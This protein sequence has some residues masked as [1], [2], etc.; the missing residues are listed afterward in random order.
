MS[1]QDASFLH[2]ENRVNPMSIASMAI[3]E[4]PAPEYDEMLKLF[5]S[6]LH[7]VPRYRQTVRFVPL[8]LARPLWVDDPHF[9]L[10][11][12][13]RHTAIPHPGS[14]EQVR[15]LMARVMSQRLDR[16][17]PLWE[18]WIADGLDGGKRWAVLSKVHHCM[19]DGVS[20]T[21]LLTIIMDDSPD[22]EPIEP[23]P[24]DPERQ[25]QPRELLAT[26]A[27]ERLTSPYEIARSLRSALRAPRR[28]RDEIR[29]VGEGLWS[30]T[31]LATQGLETQLNGPVGPHRRWS[32]AETTLDEIKKIRK[33]HGGTVNDVVLTAITRG[34]R[35]L[36]L[37]RGEPVE[38]RVVRTLVPVSVRRPDERG[39]FNNRVSAMFADLPVGI[40]DPLERLE[41]IKNEMDDLKE[42]KMAVAIEELTS[43]SGFA[44]PVLLARGARFFARMPQQNVQTVTTNVPGPQRELYACGRRMLAAYPFVP[45]GGSVRIGVAMFSYTGQLSFGVTGDYETAADIQVLCDGIERGV[46]EL[47]R[48]S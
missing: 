41:F 9:N 27:R 2:I 25:P 40:E 19:V 12:H 24:W 37:S 46:E 35:D 20:G 15:N 36:L 42:H 33:L 16:D 18:V 13:V 17:K 34:F 30:F 4:G 47:A 8:D 10:R 22:P 31:H 6:K 44:P 11:Y 32:W 5:E 43:L 3:F 21:D 23:E 1:P 29:D 48:R 14:E 26:A 39:E 28:L 7:R 38:D 45:L